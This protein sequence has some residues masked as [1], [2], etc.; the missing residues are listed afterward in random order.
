MRIV[1]FCLC[2]AIVSC[3]RPAPKTKT[4]EAR[5][6]PKVETITIEPKVWHQSIKT[7]GTFEAAEK[8]SLS[9]EFSAK[10]NTVNVT[11]GQNIEAGTTLVVFDKAEQKMRSRQ[12]DN[13]IKNAK[14]V[15]EKAKALF[16]RRETLFHQEAISKEQFDLAQNQ[17]TNAQTVYEQAVIGKSL[18]KY[19]LKRTKIVSPVS[20]TIV[21]KNVE[22]GEVALPG[23]P[24]V[25]IQVTDTMR[26]ITYVTQQE[27]N[28]VQVGAP[29]QVTTPGVRGR[30]YTAHVELRGAT[31]D[32]ITGNFPIKLT[33]E[34]KDGLLKPGMTAIVNLKGLEIN[35]AILIPESAVV[36]R[37]RKRVVYILHKNKAIEREPVLAAATIDSIIPVLHGVNAG[38]K[39]IVGG[40]SNIVHKSQVLERPRQIQTA[41]TDPKKKNNVPN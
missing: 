20:G 5:Q 41:K 28:S 35:D 29:C 30:T 33:V 32:P 36:D 12:A 37:N 39:L 13:E 34:N 10:V 6:L 1:I 21:T 31:V 23:V 19:S 7:F 27:I 14:N 16:K 8:V 15:L 17:L 25:E 24:L 18:A 22:E 40:L 3:T 2:V 9:T 4:K 11:E 38:D 26:I